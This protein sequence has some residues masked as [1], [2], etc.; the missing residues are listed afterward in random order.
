MEKKLDFGD[1]DSFELKEKE[2]IE[3]RGDSLDLAISFQFSL[4][5][6]SFI[7]NYFRLN[8]DFQG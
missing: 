1:S 5:S 7:F 3:K 6:F 2:N 4:H 8:L